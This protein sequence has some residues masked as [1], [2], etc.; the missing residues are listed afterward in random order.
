MKK[1][2]FVIHSMGYGGA[3]KSLVNLLN[4]LPENTYEVDLLLFQQKGDLLIQLPSW[5]R[6]LDEP[7]NMACLYGPIIKARKYAWF[8]IIGTLCARAARRTKKEQRAFRWKYFYSRKIRKLEK[9][10]DVA[11]AY[12]GSECLYFI[13]DKVN[14]DKKLVWIHNDYRTAGYSKEDDLSYLADMDG[15]VSVSKECV[16]VLKE[17]FPQYQQRMYCIENITSSAVIRKGAELF[18]PEEYK[19][20]KINLLSIGRLHPQKGFDLAIEEWYQL[21]LVRDR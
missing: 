18:I 2:L 16:D 20:D 5:V 14:A 17:E 11:V 21:L 4:E 1:L 6:V 7:E 19:E 15:I 9:H 3:E 12:S 13:R 10:Y 8:K